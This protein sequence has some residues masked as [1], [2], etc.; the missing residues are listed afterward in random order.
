MYDENPL[1]VTGPGAGAAVTAQG[2]LNDSIDI[3]A[4]AQFLMN[5]LMGIRV[6]GMVTRDRQTLEN[7]MR[8]TLAGL[9]A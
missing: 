1:I 6:T 3:E 2:V 5:S 4:K 9:R 7:I 8:E